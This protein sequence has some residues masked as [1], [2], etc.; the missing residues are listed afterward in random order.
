MIFFEAA[1]LNPVQDPDAAQQMFIHRIV[2]IHVELH[3]RDDTAKIGN[4]LCEHARFIHLPQDC[5]WR[6]RRG[7]NFDEEAIGFRVFAQRALMKRCAL[8]AGGRTATRTR[9]ARSAASGARSTRRD[10]RR[11][12]SGRSRA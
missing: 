9:A 12:V 11:R 4:E 10:W 6:F 3:H 2:M 8:C 7:E 1:C 5:F